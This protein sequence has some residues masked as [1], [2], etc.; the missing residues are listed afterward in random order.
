MAAHDPLHRRAAAVMAEKDILI[1][2]SQ[3]AAWSL[4]L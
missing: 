3:G 2:A 1:F 4:G